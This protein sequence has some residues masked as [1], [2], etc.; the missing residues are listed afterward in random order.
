MY[1]NGWCYKFTNQRRVSF[2]FSFY[3]NNSTLRWKGSVDEVASFVDGGKLPCLLVENKAD[4]LEGDNPGESSDL[5]SFAETN[6]FCGS[7][8]TSAKTNLNVNESMQFLI[9]NIIQR[10]EAV[11]SK[12][13]EVFSDER[14]IVNL[15]PIKHNESGQKRKQ[16]KDCC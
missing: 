13:K 16:K 2:K 11:Q 6:G 15:D 10:M 7:F 3:I 12:G 5:K 8:R 1:S 14:K 9:N 4:L